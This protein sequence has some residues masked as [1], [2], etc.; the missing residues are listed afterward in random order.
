M[1][2]LRICAVTKCLSRRNVFE[3]CTVRLSFKE[4]CQLC[5]LVRY[6]AVRSISETPLQL[7]RRNVS[8]VFPKKEDAKKRVQEQSQLLDV[9]E[10]RIQQLQTDILDVQHA[11]VHF[12]KVPSSERVAL[13]GRGSKSS[14]QDKA[15]LS[16]SGS[17]GAKPQMEKLTWEKKNK[18]KQQQ[19]LQKKCSGTVKEKP[20]PKSQSSKSISKMLPGTTH[21]TISTTAKKT[22]PLTQ[23]SKKKKTL[24]DQIRA[25][26]YPVATSAAATVKVVKPRTVSEEK[27]K[28][29]KNQHLRE[30]GRIQTDGDADGKAKELER[31]LVQKVDQWTSS[32]MSELLHDGDGEANACGDFQQSVRSY[33]E[34]CVFTENIDR[35]HRFLLSQHRMRGRRKLLNTDVYN[36]MMRLWAKKGMLHQIGRM[37]ILLEE[38]GLKPN[39]RSYCAA[40]ECMGRN[41]NCSPNVITRCLSRM[42]EDGISVDDLFNQSVFRQDERDMV[43]KAVHTIQ[44]DYLP[45]LNP[46]TSESYTS[47]VRDLYTQRADHQYP[48]L[49]FTQAELQ[50]RFQRQ[51]SVEQACTVT[52]DSVETAKPVTENMTKM[53]EQLTKHRAQWRT[54]LLQALRE[55]K[56]I[57]VNTNTKDYRLNLYPY[58]CLLEDKEYVE[59][60]IQSVANLP[61]SGES[62]RLLAADLGNRVFTK[63]AV[64]QKHQNHIVEKLANIYNT[65][66]EL[67]A[68]DT[69][70]FNILPREKWCN[71]EMEQSSGPML[72]GGELSWPH[73]ITLELGTHLVD[74]MVKNL[75]INSDILNPSH[76]R[77][78]IPILYHMYT[79]RSTRQIGF[80]KP[81]PI[82]IQMQQEA[83][84]TKLTFDSYVMP[85]LCP[86]VPW[87]SV[88]FGAYLLTP[89]KLM[90]SVDG[91]VQHE[92]L[93]EKCQNLHAVMDSLNQLGS[94]AWRINKPLL[95]IIIS[96]FNDRGSDKLDI[97]PPLSEAP[98][99]PQFNPHDHTYT[100]SEKAELRKDVVNAK[101]KCSEMHSLR[102]NALYQLSI[103]NHI[104]DDVFWFPH[105]MDFRGRTYPCPPYFN[106]LGSDVTRA[107]LVFA[108]GKPLGP[109]GLDWLKIHLVNLTGLKKRSSQEGRLEYA[110]SIMEDI[111]DSAD[112]P[113]NGKKWWMNAD[114]PWQ[115][116]ACCKEIAS[117]VRSPDPT[118]FIS[119]FPVHQD[120]SC[121]GLQHYAALGRDVIGATSV[122]LMPCDV[123]QDVYSGV[124][125]QVEELRAHDAERGLKVAQ[126]LEG[127][128][129]RKV[130]KQT[131][132]T[133][134]YGVTRY[135]GRLQIEK[136]LKEIDEFPKDHVWDASQYLVRMVF[137]ALKEMF[138]G[139]RE[140]QDWLTESA[141]LI[142]KSGH[143]VEWVTPLGL[144]I[145]Q[146]YHR[147][148]TQVIKSTMQCINLQINYDAKERPDTVKQKNAFP[149]NFIHSLDSTH[150]MLTALHCY[151][152]GLTFVSVHDCFWTHALTVDT[153]NKIC[154][155]QFVALHSQPILEE[156]SNFL[157]KKYCTGP[158]TEAKKKKYQEYKTLM[159]LLAKVPETGEF[160]LERVK[161]STY[162]FS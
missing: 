133:V 121:N 156:L 80:I 47:L 161:E 144:P 18:L 147:A 39:P 107:I 3:K 140:I 136:R 28:D 8:F 9:L 117:A 36:I 146:P 132:M 138:T 10:A 111:L 21:K 151:S 54:I 44:P 95:D 14:N 149:P 81:H 40:L 42:K 2:L 61:P 64:R 118:K 27:K 155:E 97:P 12:L 158:I 11:E 73:I 134:V 110:N 90:R 41:P 86:P 45:G 30:V 108:E 51:L 143:T 98:K 145:I 16:K 55:S 4:H 89:T 102:M 74:M 63:Y 35:A 104:R 77:K 32:G 24:S 29:L 43:L 125:Q 25:A 127:F 160:D 38:A 85:M 59:I 52:I 65:Y 78:L 101:R 53:R 100:P 57:L 103:A 114:E 105:N 150:M 91:A 157:L 46:N 56:M 112:N 152:A 142:S 106:H 87:T 148:R 50:E 162:F 93:L 49:D 94:C 129:N 71:L 119:N 6:G 70:E 60:M 84:E 13:S 126:V 79:F 92:E 15:D 58:L 68:K 153:M 154:R 130:V 120:G 19:H 1:S 137:G 5:A 75:K 115:A 48:K 96:I 83:T 76:E 82:L 23:T 20:A 17:K 72:Q 128:I 116:L 26:V 88:K 62:L 109:K 159:Q 131:V 99:I 122:N 113:L 7:Q 22:T 66:T 135:G 141:R 31:T 67:L 139:T 123:P 69:K 124:A 33:L 37:F 34:A